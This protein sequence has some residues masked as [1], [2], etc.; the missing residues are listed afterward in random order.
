MDEILDFGALFERLVADGERQHHVITGGVDVRLVRVE[1]GAAGRW[2]RHDD[3]AETVIV[4]SGTF[5]VAFRDHSISLHP[6]QCCAIPIGLDHKGTSS[7]GA[8]VILFKSASS[9]T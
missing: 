7:N 9:A 5:D 8:E 6:G 1:G 3:T 4:W 2:D